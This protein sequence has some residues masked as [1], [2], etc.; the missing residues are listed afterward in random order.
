MRTQPREVRCTSCR[1]LLAKI[2]DA[3]NLTVR[4]GDLEA[5]VSGSFRASIVCYRTSCRHRNVVDLTPSVQ[6]AA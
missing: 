2:D 4:R 1:I 3:G 5:T 6:P